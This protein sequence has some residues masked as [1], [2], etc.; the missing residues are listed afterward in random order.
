MAQH[1]F[2]TSFPN[3]GLGEALRDA[4][5]EQE[6]MNTELYTDKVDKVGGKGLSSNDYTDLE[7]TK[8]SGIEEGAEVNVQPDWLQNDNTADD[9]IKNKPATGQIITYGSY[10]LVGQNLTIFTGWVWQINGNVY[11]NS[12]DVIISFPYSSAGMQRIDLAVFNSSNSLQRVLGAEVVSNPFAPNL[13]ENTL[14]FLPVLIT[15]S[16]V[17]TSGIT[18]PFMG[19]VDQLDFEANGVDDFIDIGTTNKVKSCFYS[20]VI[21]LKSDWSQTGS[22]INFT[23][24]PL[25]GGGIKNLSFT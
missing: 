24:V 15:D 13:P 19:L 6:A 25:A 7:K 17:S 10:S 23:F 16:A 1:N 18:P 22:I 4:F 21:Q 11:T 5:N 9:Y 20:T 12:I 14:L 2:N 8:L 3:D